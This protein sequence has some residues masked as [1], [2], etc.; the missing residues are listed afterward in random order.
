MLTKYDSHPKSFNSFNNSLYQG[1]LVREPWGH[2]RLAVTLNGPLHTYQTL[3]IAVEF[4][5]SSITPAQLKFDYETTC[6]QWC[7][8]ISWFCFTQLL[9]N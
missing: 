9:F 1:C 7:Q 4:G 8:S 2:L 3:T 6:M 5:R